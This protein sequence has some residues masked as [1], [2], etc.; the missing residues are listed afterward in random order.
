MSHLET[1]ER[2]LAALRAAGGRRRLVQLA[3]AVAGLGLAT[4]HWS[5]FLL[6]G[7]LVGLAASTPGRGVLAG[8][9]VGL[10]GWLLWAGWLLASGSLSAYLGAGQPLAVSL[11]IAPLLGGVGGL[12][13]GVV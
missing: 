11:L 4:L 8:L 1:V 2:R 12:I 7:V 9:G 6:A 13:R 10:F 5:G 3:G